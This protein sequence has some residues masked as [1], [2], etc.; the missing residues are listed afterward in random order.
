MIRNNSTIPRNSPSGRRSSQQFTLIRNFPR[1]IPAD[2]LGQRNHRGTH[3]AA[4]KH[5]CRLAHD[6]NGPNHCLAS[7][8][9]A[10]ASFHGQPGLSLSRHRPTRRLQVQ[11]ASRLLLLSAQRSTF[12]TAHQRR[13]AD[14]RPSWQ[15]AS[16]KIPTCANFH[17]IALDD[18][19]K[20]MELQTKGKVTNEKHCC[21]PQYSGLFYYIQHGGL[22]R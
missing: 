11:S 19:P 8:P 1:V 16:H 13:Q 12:S 14:A 7:G 20:C 21:I 2:A 15:N 22:R 5:P 6:T 9:T 17:V 18:H 4:E 3:A 10:S